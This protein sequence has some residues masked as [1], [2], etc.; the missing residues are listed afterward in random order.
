MQDEKETIPE[1][2]YSENY[3]ER[4]KK[5]YEDLIAQLKDENQLL[6]NDYDQKLKENS[7]LQT[8]LTQK[9]QEITQ[10]SKKQ[11]GKKKVD[12]ENEQLRELL[13]DK[14]AEI[15]KIQREQRKLEKKKELVELKLKEAR[16]KTKKLANEVRKG[17]EIQV[18]LLEERRM[19]A[20]CVHKMKSEFL[21]LKSRTL[22]N[23]Q[24]S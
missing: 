1:F 22:R 12:K 4:I 8:Q 16:A 11:K 2:K 17:E 23:L 3:V 19:L 10:I 14:E 5:N 20:I 7:E 18:N 6:R 21:K 9:Q 15:D 13:E 24:D